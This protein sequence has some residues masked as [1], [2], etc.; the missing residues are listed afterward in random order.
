MALR[1]MKSSHPF[2][3]MTREMMLKNAP[4]VVAS[5]ETV[6]G[7]AC[8]VEMSMEKAKRKAIVAA[9]WLGALFGNPMTVN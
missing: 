9:E 3:A 6:G 1:A 2:L 8:H 7:L 5:A 4:F